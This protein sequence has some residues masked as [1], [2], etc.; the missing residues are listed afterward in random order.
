M[1]AGRLDVLCPRDDAG[2]SG[3]GDPVSSRDGLTPPEEATLLDPSRGLV[4]IRE[5]GEVLKK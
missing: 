4:P 2:P 1:T 3:G 5:T